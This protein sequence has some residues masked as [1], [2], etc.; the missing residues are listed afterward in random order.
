MRWHAE[1]SAGRSLAG[2]VLNWHC[3]HRARGYAAK[4]TGSASEIVIQEGNPC[5]R[6]RG[7]FQRL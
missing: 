7:I 1:I 6:G 2:A 4:V 3:E 5:R